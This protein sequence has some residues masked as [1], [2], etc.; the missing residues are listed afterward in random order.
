MMDLLP[1]LFCSFMSG[2][3]E[4][5]FCE[6]ASFRQ[7]ALVLLS[8]DVALNPGPLKFGLTLLTAG[9]LGIKVQFSVMKSKL[10]ILMFLVSPR[11]ILKL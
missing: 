4:S 8:G 9:P 6:K 2:H 7:L 1:N 3:I 5:L 11:P 10:E